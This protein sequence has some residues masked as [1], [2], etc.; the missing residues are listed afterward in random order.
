ESV[1]LH[2]LYT[3]PPLPEAIRPTL[4]ILLTPPGLG[5]VAYLAITGGPPD[6]VAHALLGYGVFQALVLLRLLRWIR[7]EP[8]GVAYWAFTFGAAALATL[9]LRMAER[10]A[11]GPAVTLAPFL[12]LAANLV[13]GAIA[14]STIAL[15]VRGRLLPRPT[16]AG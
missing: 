13:V 14:A 3:A 4:G 12:F 1:L 16:A 9:P 6:L 15:F 11:V 10:G 5:G 2:R 7:K 8:F